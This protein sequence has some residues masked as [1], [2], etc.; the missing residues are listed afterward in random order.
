MADARWD[1]WEEKYTPA[2]VSGGATGE[3][4]VTEMA[5]DT[6]G[7]ARL[8]Q[9]LIVASGMSGEAHLYRS[10]TVKAGGSWFLAVGSAMRRSPGSCVI[11]LLN[12]LVAKCPAG[13]DP[14]K[15]LGKAK[16][17]N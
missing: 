13:W 6:S 16:T 8:E 9:S 11:L 15:P 5:R 17:L 2:G 14:S 4:P 7:V 10:L 12:A 1:G 3:V